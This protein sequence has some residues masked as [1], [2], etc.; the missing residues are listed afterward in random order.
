MPQQ[1]LFGNL[2]NR[3]EIIP[4]SVIDLAKSGTIR[5]QERGVDF[6]AESALSV[7][8]E[9]H[10]EVCHLAYS[11]FLRDATLIFDPFAGWGERHHYAQQYH[12]RYIGF[13][14]NPDAIA[15]ANA[16]YHVDN[17]L[18][19]TMTVVP[20]DF[21]QPVNG[22][23]TC[24]P[25]WMRELYSDDPRGGDRQ[26]TWT[27]FLMWYK[28]IWERIVAIAAPNTTFCVV[29]GNWRK[30]HVYYDLVFQT[31]KIF[32]ELGLSPFDMVILSRKNITKIKIMIPQTLSE[33][34]TINLHEVLLV[35]RKTGG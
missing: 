6:N 3:V 23:L 26:P 32:D 8:S 4:T 14:L 33:G 13:D 28:A 9:F 11:L 12:K 2:S 17:Q 19:D 5:R 7:Y 27:A 29:V 30:D 10:P 20:T 24:P 35:Y 31:Q 25:Y 34:Y 18:R 1:D 16:T 22:I 21:D 15:Y